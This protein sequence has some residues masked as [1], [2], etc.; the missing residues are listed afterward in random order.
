[1][2]ASSKAQSYGHFRSSGKEVP[3]ADSLFQQPWWLDAV[4]PAQW[5]DVVLTRNAQVIARLPFVVNRRAGLTILTH[6]PLTPRLGPWIR[7]YAGT[8]ADRL[9]YENEVI[10]E[11]ISRLPRFDLFH[12]SLSPAIA[13]S[14]PFHWCGFTATVRY[15]YRLNDITD[16][17]AIW[18]NFTS[19]VRNQIRAAEKHVRVETNVDLETLLDLDEL[20]FR[21]QGIPVPYSRELVRRLDEACASRDARVIFV[22]VD[23]AGD[24][25]AAN[26][27]V[28]DE[29]AAHGLISANP[30][31]SLRGVSAL[32]IWSAIKFASGVT[33]AFDFEGS[34]IESIEHFNRGFGATQ[35]PYFFISKADRR[36]RVLMSL[37]EI[38]H[39]MHL[40]TIPRAGRAKI[41]ASTESL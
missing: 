11:L 6:A 21:R 17:D 1:M 16:L 24:P 14:L 18:T 20:T 26:Y 28:W 29:N 22:A 40:S 4:A 8:A 12:Q 15:T 3:W 39:A 41:V 10:R 13:S 19:E 35:V 31:R 7:P 37:R 27:F 2:V 34:M 38:A 5:E 23:E 30:S 36:M 33:A 32:L 25:Q 9:D